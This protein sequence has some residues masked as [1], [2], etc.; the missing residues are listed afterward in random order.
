VRNARGA[1]LAEIGRRLRVRGGRTD[2]NGDGLSGFGG[3][4]HV[5]AAVEDRARF[6][7]QAWRVDFAGNDGFGLNFDFAGSFY[8]A[9]EV[10]ADNDVVAVNL[11]FDFGVLAEDQGFV[12]NERALHRG[13]NAKGAGRF[14]AAFELDA[15]FQ[16]AGPLPGIMSFAV[17][18]THALSPRYM[19]SV[20]LFSHE[21]VV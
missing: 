7:D 15:L 21:L 20:A 1:S 12:G 13:I 18:P 14:Q 10:A 19:N 17:K 3:G 16:E 8:D 11:A 2:R 5:A 4:E 6:H 9:V